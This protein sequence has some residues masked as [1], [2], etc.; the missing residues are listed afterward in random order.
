MPT[1]LE[2]QIINILTLLLLTITVIVWLIKEFSKHNKTPIENFDKTTVSDLTSKNYELL[3]S[4]IQ[5]S[6]QL[7]TAA[8]NEGV[9]IASESKF[10]TTELEQRYEKILSESVDTTKQKF[11]GSIVKAD[12]EFVGYLL[13]LKSRGEQVQTLIDST[14]KQKVDDLFTKLNTNLTGVV[15]KSVADS[16][17]A[18]QK[19]LENSRSS[20]ENYKQKQIRLIDEN[21]IDVLEKTL[22]IVLVKKLTLKDQLDLVYEAL[23]KAKIEK[24]LS[25]ETTPEAPK[26]QTPAPLTPAPIQNQTPSITSQ[27]VASHQ[28]PR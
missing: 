5:K 26:P 15:T 9:K 16:L 24:F 8:E 7:I 27:P 6:E 22:S 4:T 2:G 21:I 11:Y 17:A 12:E 3:H 1:F 28:Q 10:R 14:V 13:D 18:I 20:V 25:G 19:E 23:E